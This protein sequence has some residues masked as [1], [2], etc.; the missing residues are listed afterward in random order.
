MEAQLNRNL[1]MAQT[2][3]RLKAKS[4]ASKLAKERDA[5]SMQN[6]I[7]NTQ[8]PAISEEEIL[9]IFSTGEAVERTPRGTTPKKSNGKK[10]KGKK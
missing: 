2:K 5:A 4:E 7:N 1:K 8:L 3:E 6:N 10:K 9:K